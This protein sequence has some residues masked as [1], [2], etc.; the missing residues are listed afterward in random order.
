MKIELRTVIKLPA[1]WLGWLMVMAIT[2]LAQQPPRPI[3]TMT[4][5]QV[6]VPPPA[7]P[8]SN[9]NKAESVK[10]PEAQDANQ[11][12][13]EKAWNEN[14]AKLRERVKELERRADQAE[15]EVN[16]LRNFL[17]SAEPRDAGANGKALARSAELTDL[18][19]KLR[20]EAK[21]TQREVDELLAEGE[22]KKYKI[23]TLS[24]TTK[25]G[26]PNLDYYQSRLAEL[27]TE[28]NDAQ[29]RAQ[30]MQLRINE[31]R[32]RI[33]GNSGSGDSFFLGRLRDELDEAQKGLEKAQTRV[34]AAL[35][36]LEALRKQA[37]EA[38]VELSE[39]K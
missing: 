1:V 6:S 16:R 25:S 38:G 36:K 17:F 20:A 22:A 32:L 2:A 27:Q 19:Q 5:E 30:V 10:T 9:A 23:A 13:A 3:P 7:V 29:A 37:R 24:P 4:G 34:A 28:L 26:D 8:A 33:N 12:A 39:L 31:L 11:D 35:E 21:A 14:L 18:A 15:L